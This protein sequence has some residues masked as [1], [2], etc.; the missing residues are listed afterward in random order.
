MSLCKIAAVAI[1]FIT[2]A[3]GLS[4]I[5]LGQILHNFFISHGSLLGVYVFTCVRTCSARI[6]GISAV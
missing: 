1:T 5:L 2:L 3:E 4:P 6:D